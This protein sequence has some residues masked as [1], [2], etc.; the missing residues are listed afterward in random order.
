MLESAMFHTKPDP[1]C[2]GSLAAKPMTSSLQIMVW[3]EDLFAIFWRFQGKP[4]KMGTRKMHWRILKDTAWF[5]QCSLDGFF[6]EQWRGA[7]LFLPVW[8]EV[9]TNHSGKHGSQKIH[10]GQ[11][12]RNQS[13]KNKQNWCHWEAPCWCWWGEVDSFFQGKQ[14]DLCPA[15]VKSSWL[16]G[17]WSIALSHPIDPFPLMLNTL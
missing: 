15:D 17:P 8:R 5:H 13:I 4:G 9:S 14:S 7:P 16:I 6:S 1:R 10:E 11:T 12:C 3:R 2:C